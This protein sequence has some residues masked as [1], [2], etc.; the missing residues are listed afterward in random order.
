[1]G[2]HGVQGKKK[3]ESASASQPASQ[4]RGHVAGAMPID[5][6][7]PPLSGPKRICCVWSGAC[8]RT[9]KYP[10]LAD[11]RLYYAGRAIGSLPSL[12]YSIPCH[13]MSVCRVRRA[14]LYPR[15]ASCTPNLLMH[16]LPVHYPPRAKIPDA[17]HAP[18]NLASHLAI[19]CPRCLFVAPVAAS[20]RI[21]IHDM[22][23]IMMM[24]TMLLLLLLLMTMTTTY[25]GWHAPEVRSAS[26]PVE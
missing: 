9:R 26:L 10:R 23:M 17:Y 13:A 5:C 12:A 8:A 4:Y 1:M 21:H 22:M 25:V 3:F 7:M 20:G 6:P 18:P 16:P 14:T 24:M 11:S 19:Y 2:H 15:Y